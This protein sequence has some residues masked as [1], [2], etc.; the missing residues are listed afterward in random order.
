MRLEG[1]GSPASLSPREASSI[2]LEPPSCKDYHFSKAVKL[3]FLFS[4]TVS[5]SF[6]F[7]ARSYSFSFLVFSF[8]YSSFFSFH[9][10]KAWKSSQCFPYSSPLFWDGQKYKESFIQAPG[11]LTTRRGWGLRYS[12]AG[13]RLSSRHF[14]LP[15][16]SC[17]FPPASSLPLFSLL[18][19]LS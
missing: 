4:A 19:F 2:P 6:C 3:S 17:F 7:F 8:R 14:L 11:P 9:F 12:P 16:S 5:S 15:S 10:S 18:P 1:M 13:P